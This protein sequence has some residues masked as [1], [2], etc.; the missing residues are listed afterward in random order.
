MYNADVPRGRSA[1]K[2]EGVAMAGTAKP[3]VKWVGGKR[4][5]L[6]EIRK[7]MPEKYGTYFE[8]FFGGGAVFF[9]LMPKSAV[10]ND[11]NTQLMNLYQQI[12][13]DADELQEIMSL[14]TKEYNE[15]E[16]VEAKDAYFYSKREEYNQCIK[17][18]EFSVKSAAL[19]V[20]LNKASFNGV[21]RLNKSGLYNVPCAHRMT[22]N[23]PSDEDIKAAADALKSAVILHGDFE[24]ACAAVQ[25]GD[26]VFFDS[27]YYDTFDTYQAGGFSDEDHLRLFRL[28]Q[29]L[30]KLG[31]YCML[32]N[33]NCDYIK[34]LYKDYNIS[35]VDVKRMV[36]RDSSNR[37]GQEVIITNYIPFKES[38]SFFEEMD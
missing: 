2:K 13:T 14:W 3:L 36:N 29:R 38:I 34:N 26:F 37:V 7:N 18:N 22:L 21:Y 35:V 11:Y 30:D 28:F 6:G 5:L 25:A 12:Q 15:L 16:A 4:Q 24:N 17:N 23:M 32:T 33:S 10:I 8:P 20:F 31:A 1:Q 9:D 27:P 19:F